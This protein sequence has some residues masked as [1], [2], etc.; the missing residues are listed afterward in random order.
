LLDKVV[1]QA[2]KVYGTFYVKRDGTPRLGA[3]HVFNLTKVLCA[4]VTTRGVG[5]KVP[6]IGWGIRVRTYLTCGL[7]VQDYI[8]TVV[9]DDLTRP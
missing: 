8:T 5:N 9:P 7:V 4:Q 3:V 1:N 2:N 6:Y